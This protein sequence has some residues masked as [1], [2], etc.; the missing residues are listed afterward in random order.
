M[1]HSRSLIYQ[2]DWWLL[3]VVVVVQVRFGLHGNVSMFWLRA[4]MFVMRARSVV[5]GT[6]ERGD[7]R[8]DLFFTINLLEFRVGR[9]CWRFYAVGETHLR[10]CM[11]RGRYKWNDVAG[12]RSPPRKWIG[13]FWIRTL[14]FSW[15]CVEEELCRQNW[16][17]CQ[18][19]KRLHYILQT[20][21]RLLSA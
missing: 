9:C 3:V 13:T 8:L 15:K 12:L 1:L 20:H 2:V 21:T 4:T 16:H 10:I 7:A 14:Y 6:Y 18:S 11:D 19:L 17:A 5:L